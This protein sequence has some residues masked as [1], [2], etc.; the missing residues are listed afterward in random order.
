MVDF[1]QLLVAVLVC[2]GSRLPWEHLLSSR[3][4][5]SALPILNGLGAMPL[6]QLLAGLAVPLVGLLNDELVLKLTFPFVVG[7]YNFHMRC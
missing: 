3:R 7:M 6:R 4:L 5:V 2:L 1:F